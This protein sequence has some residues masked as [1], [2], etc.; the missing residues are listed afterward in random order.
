M[1]AKSTAASGAPSSTKPRPP[2]RPKFLRKSQK[3]VRPLLSPD[4]KKS[5]QVQ[6]WWYRI[7]VTTQ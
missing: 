6:N 1:T 5:P 7:A 3:W 4:A 2:A